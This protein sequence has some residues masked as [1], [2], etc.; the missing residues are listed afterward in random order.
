MLGPFQGMLKDVEGRGLTGEH[1]DAM[2]AALGRMLALSQS[3]SDL[4]SYTAKLGT[5]GL[6]LAFSNAYTKALTAQAA[7]APQPTDDAGLLRQMLAAYED[8]RRRLAQAPNQ[9][10]L[11]PPLLRALELGQSG[12]T[13]PAFLRRCEEEHLFERMKAGDARPGLAF[14]LH[15]AEV[16]GD[17]VRTELGRALLACHDELARKQAAGVPEPLEFELA[18]QRLEWDYAPRLAE[19]RSI[20][21]HWQVLHELCFD[22]LDAHCEF[23]PRDARWASTAG[24]QATLLNIQRSKEKLPG[25][26]AVRER[27]LTEYHGLRF[28]DV[29][30][31]PTWAAEVA[32]CRVFD[33]DERLEL[34]R[35]T[36]PTCR[37][38][39]QPPADV[40]A[41]NEALYRAGTLRNPRH[42]QRFGDA[43]RPGP[44]YDFQAFSKFVQA[45][46]TNGAAR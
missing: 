7:Q 29:W 12:L 19:W 38:G 2:R 15:C 27:L 5:E 24:P 16:M 8:A 33:S 18:R 28:D 11:L 9:A 21:E 32:A 17:P 39:S 36:W 22:W 14:E 10:H 42:A 41:R 31:H 23:A 35:R 45:R 6:F 13:Y 37:P 46:S 20:I 4:G 34:L 26:L 30:A 1:V 25:Q 43:A 44:G 3:M 40:V